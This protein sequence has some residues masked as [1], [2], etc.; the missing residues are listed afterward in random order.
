MLIGKKITL[1]KSALGLESR[2]GKSYPI[3]IPA[4]ATVQF[5]SEPTYDN[6]LASALWDYREVAIF[7]SWIPDESEMSEP[8][9]SPW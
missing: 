5:T 3:S 1:N 6:G 8:E 2:G 4:G 9:G 7:L